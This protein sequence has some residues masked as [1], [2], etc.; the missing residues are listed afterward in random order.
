MVQRR[1]VLG[2]AGI[3]ITG[4]LAGCSE[5]SDF[6]MDGEAE[7]DANPAYVPK[8][9]LSNGFRI[10]DLEKYEIE[11]DV[12]DRDIRINAWMTEHAKKVE[13]EI[14]EEPFEGDLVQFLSLSLPEA[15]I[16][17]DD[18]L[19][20]ADSSPEEILN[21]LEERYEDAS[22]YGYDYEK[23][24]EDKKEVLGQ[25]V[26]VGRFRLD[27]DWDDVI[28]EDPEEVFGVEDP[29]VILLLSETVNNEGD[30]VLG[31]GAYPSV[32]EEEHGEVYED[33][34]VTNLESEIESMFEEIEHPVNQEEI[35]N[36][37]EE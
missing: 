15:D 29:D 14:G 28:D 6:I 33:L 20:I 10:V 19:P 27:P 18:A 31:A 37:I 34:N 36:E 1:T 12:F 26:T 4:G 17:V 22:K 21:E 5:L 30:H 3:G 23:V 13:V 11:E 32:D 2:A 9:S 25:T 8:S 7:F 16:G 24:D 35:E